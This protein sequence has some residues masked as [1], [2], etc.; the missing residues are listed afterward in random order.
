MAK[1][2]AS[3]SSIGEQVAPAARN[4]VDHRLARGFG[5]PHGVLIGVDVDALV[6]V[7]E[8]G[9]RGEREMRLGKDGQAGQRGGAGGIAEEAAAGKA[10]TSYRIFSE[11]S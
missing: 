6:G 10:T 9:A 5:G 8:V 4:D 2:S 3:S 1:I 7:G 11:Y